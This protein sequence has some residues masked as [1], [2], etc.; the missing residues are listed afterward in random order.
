[1]SHL[2]RQVRI[3][4]IALALLSFGCTPSD[5]F[6]SENASQQPPV[7]GEPTP[8][9]T[10]E[11]SPAPT[12][13]PQPV[14]ENRNLVVPEGQTK[15]LRIRLS[16]DP[17][18]SVQVDVAVT[19]NDGSIEMQGSASLSFDS[20]NWNQYQGVAFLAKQDADASDGAATV[21]VTLG[22]TRLTALVVAADDEVPSGTGL[23][24]TVKDGSGNGLVN[25]PVTVVVPLEFG[26]Y[27]NIDNF[28]LTDA[29]GNQIPAQ[30]DVLNRWWGR[31][32]SIR[33]VIAH[34]QASATPFGRSYVFF[35][36]DG[37]ATATP[38]KPVSVV[39][40]ATG[41]TVDTG[42]VKF[43]MLKQGFNIFHEVWHD[44]NGDGTYDAAER[45]I[46][47]GSE[48]PVFTGRNAGDIQRAK[49]R[50]GL[51]IEVEESGPMRA[52]IRIRSLSHFTSTDDHDHGFVMRLI[53]Y[54]GKPYVKADYQL[55]NAAKNVRFSWPLYF[56]DMS[57]V[58]KPTLTG[59]KARFAMMPG[60]HVDGPTG[61]YLLQSKGSLASVH[62]A[63][64]AQVDVRTMQEGES[65]Y[66][67]A[68]IYDANRGM[69]VFVRYM[70]ET[71]PNGIEIA[72][73]NNVSVRL[74]PKWSAQSLIASSAISSTGLYWIED[75]QAVRKE[76]IFYFHGAGVS[77]DELDAMATR[78]QWR[79]AAVVPYAEYRRTGVTL[80]AD[81]I[82]PAVHK[83]DNRPD[84]FRPLYL[85]KDKTN[86]EHGYYSFGWANFRGNVSRRSQ[87]NA[88]SYPESGQAFYVYGRM[89]DLYEAER[90]VLGDLNCRPMWMEG[91]N[92]D[93]DNTRLHLSVNPW[94]AETWRAFDGHGIL[95]EAAPRLA[96]TPWWMWE[97]HD[98]EHC[99]LYDI[100]EYYYL[101]GDPWVRD[102]YKFLVEFRKRT[103]FRPVGA[104][105]G[106][107][108]FEWSFETR[109]EG[110]FLS[111]VMQAY[112]VTGDAQLLD[113]IKQRLN[114]LRN[115]S[116][117]YSVIDPAIG[118]M[119]DGEASFQAG[120]LM[121]GLAAVYDEFQDGPHRQ[122]ADRA[123]LSLWGANDWHQERCQYRYYSTDGYGPSSG[124]A[125]VT[126]DAVALWYLWSGDSRVLAPM[127]QYVENGLLGGSRPYDD[128]SGYEGQWVS[129]VYT[130]LQQEPKTNTT[131]AARITDL[132]ASSPAA[133]KVRIDWT[134]PANATR[135]LI[136]YSEL[137]IVEA[138]TLDPNVRNFW[139]A[140]VVKH[141]LDVTPGQKQSLEF[142]APTGKTVYAAICTLT[143]D[144]NLS[145]V[146]N[147]PSIAVK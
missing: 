111:N 52:M 66:G 42:V 147:I 26:K 131:P 112:R 135:Y 36:K 128:W 127:K 5:L 67:W 124:S 62:D 3:L 38:A 55:M 138:Y 142:D 68:D 6:R 2:T 141:S 129:R 37:P 34:F 146:S 33:H 8:N 101:T 14:L 29:D 71:Y 81:G 95:P 107:D 39:E 94:G 76:T 108:N 80:D 86:P 99:W 51:K 90:L 19:G 47:P 92:Y 64:G 133:G 63:N 115:E 123:Y 54:A 17:G 82:L 132:S 104:A 48:G 56:E 43:R 41:I 40:D 23:R 75:M 83:A 140:K 119:H 7:I 60:A 12:G 31:D 57:L 53:A 130:A 74:W 120:Y 89:T 25:A 21:D 24:L 103:L 106:H 22:Q 28:H 18:G 46:E 110:H 20:S 59:A 109:G 27:Q 126:P 145:K 113:G 61:R 77:N 45:V 143:A 100:E 105:P 144:K 69:A 96:N 10:P 87:S 9:P 125:L 32:N 85:G 30:I 79:P 35:R 121:R 16:A 84:T 134:A 49:D 65:S 72:A 70:A 102:F 58:V 44:T 15:D 117:Q 116:T 118:M 137:P 91:Y 139:G 78:F 136:V 1:M 114:W 98:N 93:A 122:V 11:P 50:T 4:G 88:G 13:S 73:D 97:P